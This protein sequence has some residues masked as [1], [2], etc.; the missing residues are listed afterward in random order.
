[1]GWLL[2]TVRICRVSPPEAPSAAEFPVYEI[3]LWDESDHAAIINGREI[4]LLDICS[5]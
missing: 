5:A 1:M 4:L 3:G 2:D